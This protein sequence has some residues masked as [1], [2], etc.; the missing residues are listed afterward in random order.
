MRLRS[1]ITTGNV[2]KLMSA[3]S[4]EALLGTN[5][6]RATHYTWNYVNY[7]INGFATS[8]VGVTSYHA[9]TPFSNNVAPPF[10]LT[11]MCMKNLFPLSSVL[12]TPLL[13]LV[14]T[15]LEEVRSIGAR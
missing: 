12:V 13:R 3:P 14:H 11:R 8:R 7:L 4:Q 10:S 2:S 1:R 15:V 9:F 5:C 6:H